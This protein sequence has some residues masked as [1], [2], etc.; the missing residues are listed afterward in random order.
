M[1]TALIIIVIII[2]TLV[3]LYFTLIGNTDRSEPK[4]ITI[5]QSIYV[6][7]LEINTDDN[8]IYQDV[9][10][11][12]AQFNEIKRNY[13]VPNLKEPWSSINISKDYN[14]E[15]GTFTYVVG[16]V[17]TVVDSIPPGLKSYEIPPL[18][19]A[20]F[21]IKPKSKLAWGITMGRMK[22]FIYKEWLPISAY[23]PSDSFGE[24]ELHDERS[25]GMYPEINLY[26]AIDRTDNK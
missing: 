4:I 3:I 18:T 2:A 10:K 24:F 6:I 13:P 17:V 19:Y 16:D 21:R 26:V 7:G 5:E 8:A 23:K 14:P 1:K 22:K 15:T 25:L 20:V 12:A 9:S 11:V